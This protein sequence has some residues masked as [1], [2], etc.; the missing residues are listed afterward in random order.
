MLLMPKKLLDRFI[1]VR[2]QD[3]SGRPVEG[4]SLT[5]FS[6]D[7]K[8]AVIPA[9]GEKNPTLQFADRKAVISLQ[10]NIKSSKYRCKVRLDQNQTEWVFTIPSKSLPK[11]IFIGCSLEG[12]NEASIIQK[13]LAHYADTIIWSQGVFGLSRSTLETLVEKAGT[14]THAILIL[15][16]DDM[17]I[18]RSDEVI[19]AR[20]NV[21]FELGL[22]MGALGRTRTFIVAERSVKLP[23]DL[24]GI[25]TARF[26]R[27]K[28]ISIEA[29]MGSV[30]TTLRQ[31]I[32]LL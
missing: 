26:E 3:E 23:T 25:T 1:E 21:L 5:I 4:A 2:I 31:E 19:A 22:F 30:V 28:G 13:L 18:K 29:N 17:L 24:D 10:V 7:K 8:I 6:N 32:G 16:P 14:F 15:T 11:R 12:H 27:G 9:T 20:D